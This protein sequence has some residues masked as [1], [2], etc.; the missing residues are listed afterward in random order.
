MNSIFDVFYG[1]ATTD[2]VEDV[3]L[4]RVDRGP[5]AFQ[6]FHVIA[7]NKDIN[8]LPDLALLVQDVPLAG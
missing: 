7:P 6:P 1:L 4:I 8:V 2:G 5:Q 3:N